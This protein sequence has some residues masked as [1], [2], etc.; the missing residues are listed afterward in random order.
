MH[1]E[2]NER[3]RL[4][5]E[6]YSKTFSLKTSIKIVSKKFQVDPATLRVDWSRRHKWPKEVLGQL[7]DP[8][9]IDFYHLGIHRTLRQIERELTQTTNPS[10]RVGLLRT[11]A[12]ILFKLLDFQKGDVEKEVL[13]KRIENLEKALQSSNQKSYWVK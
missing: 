10:C 1:S 8:L 9:L 5:I 3:R 4:M 13:T 11:K 7:N 6:V 2:V 12:D